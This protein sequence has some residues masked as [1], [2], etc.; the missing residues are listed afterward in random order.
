MQKIEDGGWKIEDRKTRLAPARLFAALTTA[1]VHPL[2]SILV[3]VLALSALTACRQQMAEQPRYD[4]LEPS[5]FWA[6]GQSAR[7][8]VE[9][10]VARGEL[11][12]NEQFYAGGSANAI[13]ID[14]P[15]PITMETLRRGQERYN[16]YCAPCHD[17]VGTGNGM[18]VQRGFPRAASYHTEILRKQPVGHFFRVMTQGFGAMPSYAAQVPVADRWAIIAYI[19]ALQLSQNASVDDVAPEFRAKMQER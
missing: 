3:F 8:L 6:D 2:S 1:I 18:I 7:P 11:R 15:I 13:A 4:P 10:T 12:D 19:R 9:G 16:I 14:V 5:T 17:R